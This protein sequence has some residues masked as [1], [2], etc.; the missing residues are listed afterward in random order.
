MVRGRSSF[1]WVA[2]ILMSIWVTQIELLK[3]N[4]GHE[5]ERSKDWGGSGRSQKRGRERNLNRFVCIDDI[6]KKLIKHFNRQI[7][8]I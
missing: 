7:N 6:L 1:Q 3:K 5:V 4:R 2:H 8:T